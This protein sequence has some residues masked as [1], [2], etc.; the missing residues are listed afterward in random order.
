M[1][2]AKFLKNNVICRVLLQT[3]IVLKTPLAIMHTIHLKKCK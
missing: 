3:N 2:F 1:T